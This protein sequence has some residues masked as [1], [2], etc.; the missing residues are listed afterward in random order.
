MNH[1]LPVCFS[2]AHED[3]NFLLLNMLHLPSAFYPINSTT[4][5]CFSLDR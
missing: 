2:Y 3:E 5:V 4:H 1:T